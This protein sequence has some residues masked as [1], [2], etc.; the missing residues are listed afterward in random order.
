MEEI[1][2]VNGT[3]YKIVIDAYLTNYQDR[4]VYEAVAISTDDTPDEYN[5]V[6][7]WSLLYEIPYDI[8]PDTFDASVEI[9]WDSPDEVLPYGGAFNQGSYKLD[10][11]RIV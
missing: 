8:D 11:N 5:T 4:A 6:P 10:E 9:D 1:I 3:S 2:T 7:A